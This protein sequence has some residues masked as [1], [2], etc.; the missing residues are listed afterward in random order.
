MESASI[1]YEN[2]RSICDH[3]VERSATLFLGAGVNFGVVSE[4]GVPCPLGGELSAWI[5]RDLLESPETVVPLDEAAEMARHAFGERAFNDYLFN[6][7]GNFHPGVV[8]LE[9][10][11]LPWDKIFTTNF[12]LLI[13]EAAA[14]GKVQTAGN[15]IVVGNT[16][17]DVSSL[18]EEDIPYFKLHGSLDTANTDSGKL[19]L[20]KKDYREYEKYKKPLFKRLK[21]DL[22]SRT[23]L[24]LGYALGDTNFREVLDDCREE[25]GAQTLP[26]SYA[27]VKHFTPVQQQYW[28]DKYNL[29]LIQADAVEFVTC[30][31]E[32]WVSEGC[33]VVPL[34]QRKAAEYLQFGTQTRFQKIGDSFYLLR[35]TDC[36]GKSNPQQFFLG[37]EPTWADIRD[38]VPAKRDLYD[39]LLEAMF[40][41]LV[42]VNLEASAYVITGPAGTGKTTLLY[43]VAYD[44]VADFQA[45]VLIHIPGTPLDSRLIAPLVNAEDPRRF[46]VVVRFASEQIREIATF[47]NE[48]RNRKLPVTLLL[49]DRT[50][51]WHVA[52]STFS[53]KFSPLEFELRALS[54]EEISA[55]LEALTKY[56]CLG[57]LTGVTREE[58]ISHF[59]DLA[60]EDLL[61]ALRELTSEGNFDQII[62]DEYMKIPSPIAQRAYL[63]VA[64]VGQLDLAMRYETIIRILGIGTE[65]LAANLLN[66]TEGI[67]ITGED[68]GSSR[69]NLGFRLR[70]R[71]PIIASII[72]AI[73]AEDD[74]KKFAVINE[75]L[76]ELDPGFPEDI[77]LLR[78]IMQRKELVNTLAAH[79]MRRALFERLEA[80]LPGDPFVWQH[81]SVLERDLQDA[82]QAVHFARSATKA[83][84]TN[85]M[86]ANTLGFALELAARK[87]EDSLKKQAFLSEATKLFEEGIK[88]SPTDPYNYLGQL[89]IL[90]QKIDSEKDAKNRAYLIANSLSLLTEAFEDTNESPMIA[91]ELA[92]VRKQLGSIDEGIDIVKEALKKKPTE[93]RLRD[94]LIT[95]LNDKGEHD[96]ALTVAIEGA[97]LDP[98]SWRI[99]RWLARLRQ[100]GQ[101]VVP[102]VRGN[103][104]AAIRHHKGDV[105]LL[106]EYGSYLF[107]KLLLDDANSVFEELAALSMS[108]QERRMIREK[109]KAE[110]GRPRVFSGTIDRFV[111]AR[112]RILAIPENFHVHFW[113]DSR[114][115]N[116][117]REGGTVRFT[118]GFTAQG[119]EARIMNVQVPDR[120][121]TR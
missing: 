98:T 111:G 15:I 34:L 99:Q 20:T 13:E 37:A 96:A 55:T 75:I 119:P 7:F 47:Y 116:N 97:K 80:I 110:D 74:A 5:C 109:W 106:V 82:D 83:M 33:T 73:A 1:P 87:S 89:Q 117:Q 90:R 23:F 25:L 108:S 31:K 42:D 56:G 81:R 44:I 65:Q 121:T 107:R 66:P 36:T 91:G 22:E 71:H 16:T 61:V 41:E 114:T 40:P 27:V 92:K 43:T 2:I 11:Q 60:S 53:T 115:A 52:Q 17:S 18:T 10:V 35:T 95:F 84:P 86:F 113:R 29:E 46:V 94:L 103:Y 57:K 104:V 45:G 102:A 4:D 78:Q 6:K 72:F 51:Q 120:L 67:L 38:K 76:S 8:H 77:R 105:G 12:D 24:F 64:A 49:E 21:A 59:N 58:Q 62:R 50:N 26:L 79:A 9:L 39:P 118:V 69:H 88:K 70:A 19:I 14:C 32:T 85:Q 3:L 48:A 68:T 28:R 63:Y 54:A 30:L 93:S 101:E 112:G 100:H